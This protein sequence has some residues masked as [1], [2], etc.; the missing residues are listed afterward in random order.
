MFLHDAWQQR[1][2]VSSLNHLGII[3]GESGHKSPP[4]SA[5]HANRSPTHRNESTLNELRRARAKAGS[6]GQ[7]GHANKAADSYGDQ[8]RARDAH[9]AAARVVSRRG[10][11]HG[12]AVVDS[13]SGA[14]CT[15]P[16]G[17]AL[18]REPGAPRREAARAASRTGDAETR[19]ARRHAAPAAKDAA[20]VQTRPAETRER[21]GPPRL[22]PRTRPS[23]DSSMA[24]A[25][26][27]MPL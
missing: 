14:T 22:A 2:P 20:A 1:G 6:P 15:A 27:L 19:R 25:G 3:F 10:A 26:E 11:A 23:A 12:V 13:G 4:N 18:L 7:H 9:E 24:N 8:S 21:L 16:R 17:L 5:S